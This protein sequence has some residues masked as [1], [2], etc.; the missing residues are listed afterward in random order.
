MTNWKRKEVIGDCTLCLGD[1]M[2]IMPTLPKSDLCVSDVPYALT[3]G[4]KSKSSKSMSG[5]F[6]AHNYANDG[7]L[8]MAT[9][10]FPEMMAA[11]YDALKDNADCYVMSNDKN[12]FPLWES[13]TAA[14]FKF[15]NLLSWDKVT[16]T[17]NRWYMKHIEFTLYLWKGGAKTINF[18]NSKQQL[19]GG[20]R[21]ESDHPTEK[22]V[23]LMSEYIRNSSEA[24]DVV[25][26]CFMGGGTTGV[27]C[28]RARRRFV[29]IE[30]DEK[31]FLSACDRIQSA[32]D[33]PTMFSQNFQMPE[34]QEALFNG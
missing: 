34:H 18:P 4:G 3:T 28:L 11:I 31:H 16:P 2:E 17:A 29:G 10:P 30:I 13:G 7:Q 14:G 22:P 27:A 8:V 5:I 20:E 23:A 1:A 6:A 25:L 21:S 9:V 15:H 19:R 33:N 12:L 26:D 24:G 32:H